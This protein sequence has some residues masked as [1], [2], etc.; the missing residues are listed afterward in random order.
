MLMA[1][2][3]PVRASALLPT[4]QA[5]LHTQ[6]LRASISDMYDTVAEAG[7]A[8]LINIRTAPAYSS[9]PILL[10][11][12]QDTYQQQESCSCFCWHCSVDILGSQ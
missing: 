3:I 2:G 5:G 1:Y 7:R 10:L 12:L 11:P 6:G 9:L 4:V 8:D